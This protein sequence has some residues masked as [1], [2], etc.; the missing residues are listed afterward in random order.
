MTE[1]GIEVKIVVDDTTENEKYTIGIVDTDEIKVSK[2]EVQEINSQIIKDIQEDGCTL[3]TADGEWTIIDL[4]DETE[5][6]KDEYGVYRTDLTYEE[7][8][9]RTIE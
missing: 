1:I 4:V 3:I 7:I 8:I 9:E 6:Y 5:Y 2:E